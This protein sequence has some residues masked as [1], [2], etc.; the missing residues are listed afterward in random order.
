[1]SPV[2]PVDVY[3]KV[4]IGVAGT[5]MPQFEETLVPE[6][7][8]AVAT[9]V[10]T[11]RAG[12]GEEREGEGLYAAHCASCHGATGG[13]DGPLAASL[14]VQPPALRDLAIQGRFS[15]GE[16]IELILHGRP[17]TPMPGFAHALDRSSAAKL[18]AFLRVLPTAER[19]RHEAT[20]PATATFEAVRRQ[21]DSAVALRSGPLAFDAYLT[22]EQVETA[23]RARNPGLASEL[24]G[25]FAAVRARAA[26]GAG[27]EALDAI[28]AR[29]LSGRAAARGAG[30]GSRCAA[31][32][33]H[34][35]VCSRLP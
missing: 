6:D 20:S 24:E 3:R 13:G 5:A 32:L 35:S 34:E 21:V 19:Q 16:L 23:V 18:V 17:G 26:G 31:Q 22:F 10:A 12:S 1:M 8:W 33:V 28:H 9:Y 4:T 30:A 27:R 14:S 15:D 7:R 11:L 29:P 2:S 25:A